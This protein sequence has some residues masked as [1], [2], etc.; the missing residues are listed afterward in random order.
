MRSLVDALRTKQLLLVLD[1]CEHLLAPSAAIAAAL[2]ADCPRVRVLATSREPLGIPGELAWSVAPLEFPSATAVPYDDDVLAV[3]AVQLFVDR[4]RLA[5]PG[6]V[7]TSATAAAMAQICRQLD[8]LPLAIEL[9]ASRMRGL[10]VEDLRTRLG[11]RLRLLVGGPRTAQARHQTL[12]AAIEWSYDLLTPAE[13]VLF[14]RLAVFAGGW[15]LDAVEAVFPDSVQP[16]ADLLVRLVE[17]SLVVAEIAP[18]GMSA[19]YRFLETVREFAYE[20]LTGS[21]DAAVVRQRHAMH[22]L[23]VAQQADAETFGP[24]IV[25]AFERLERERDN[26]RAAL[27]WLMDEGNA[28]MGMRFAAALARFWAVNGYLREA[29][30]WL[31]GFLA[32]PES[33]PLTAARAKALSALCLVMRDVGSLRLGWEVGMQARV[34]TGTTWRCC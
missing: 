13:R 28:E 12:H 16:V 14:E 26:C 11:Q 21:S 30:E 20:Q 19:R 4:A 10:S 8:G 22:Y 29:Q 25:T 1:N 9:A 24:T 5:L 15:T 2:V 33:D 7:P 3:P 32:L 17:K 31:E 27:A 34:A 23:A 18:D 6:F